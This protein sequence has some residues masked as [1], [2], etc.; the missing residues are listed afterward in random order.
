[1]SMPQLQTR[2]LLLRTPALEDFESWA[3]LHQ[4]PEVT[5]YIGGLQ[6]R[7]T[8]FRGLLAMA[9]AWSLQGFGMFSVFE[10][11]TGRWIGRVG[12]WCPEGWPGTEVGWSLLRDAWG[13]GYALE[14]AVASIDWAFANLDWDEVIHT[15][16]PANQA[17]QNLALRLGSQRRGPGRLPP[18]FEDA[19]VEIWGQSRAQWR[20]SRAQLEGVIG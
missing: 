12:P 4:D 1:M 17:S 5:R 6:P 15:I 2:R 10:R 3:A 19:T 8:V 18:P 14:A 13:Q 11:A 9:G 7:A 20:D 16:D